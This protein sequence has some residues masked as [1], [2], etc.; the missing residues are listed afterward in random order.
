MCEV[1]L[2]EIKSLFLSGVPSRVQKV[3]CIGMIVRGPLVEMIG[4][5]KCRRVWRSVFEV[6]YDNLVGR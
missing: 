1:R 2:V 5:V 6:Y 4:N 3:W